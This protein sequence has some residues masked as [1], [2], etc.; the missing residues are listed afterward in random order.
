MLAERRC[1][2][3][4]CSVINLIRNVLALDV[5]CILKNKLGMADL[6]SDSLKNPFRSHDEFLQMLNHPVLKVE[7]V[8]R[9]ALATILL[10]MPSDKCNA[11]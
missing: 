9:M 2:A 7:A 1:L 6:L 10:P 5:L 11:L 3:A 8:A 4:V